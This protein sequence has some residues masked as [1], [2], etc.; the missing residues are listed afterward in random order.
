MTNITPNNGSIINCANI[1][2]GIGWILSKIF[3]YVL[4]YQAN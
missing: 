4:E 3:N 2:L 1:V